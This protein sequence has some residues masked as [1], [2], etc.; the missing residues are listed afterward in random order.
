MPPLSSHFRAH[1]GRVSQA[2]GLQRSQ[3]QVSFLGNF[4]I[5]PLHTTFTTRTAGRYYV[6]CY[7][8]RNRACKCRPYCTATLR[9][10][11]GAGYVDHN[12]TKD[13]ALMANTSINM[14]SP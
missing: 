5:N 13:V 3:F 7:Y 10:T 12:R 4:Q 14:P 1:Q 6:Q 11:L 9:G 2:H 8:V